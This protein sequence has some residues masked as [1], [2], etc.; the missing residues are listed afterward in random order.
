MI[1]RTMTITVLAIVLLHG[2]VHAQSIVPDPALPIGPFVSFHSD[3][4]QSETPA[5]G[6]A[7]TPVAPDGHTHT[8]SHDGLLHFSHPLI[9]ESPSPDT[10][11]R[12]D[13]FFRKV[14]G[15]ASYEHTARF[16][17]E[18]AFFPWLSAEVDAPYTYIDSDVDG[19]RSNLDTV[20]VAVKYA[21][22]TFAQHGVLVGGGIELG[23]PTGDDDKGIGSD[24]EL[25]VAPYIDA[26]WKVGPFELVGFLEFGIPVN[27][28][29]D[30]KDEVDLELGYNV[31]LLY[32]VTP[33]IEAIIELNGGSVALGEENEA[34]LNLSPGVKVQPWPNLPLQ[35]GVGVSFPL[36]GD[37]AYDV[38][39]ILSVFLHF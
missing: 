12:F 16:E 22:F 14:E 10:K 9:T 31:S 38:Q 4:A 21:N 19:H 6:P 37:D 8:H 17:G 24:H 20:S 23:L 32:H 30:E 39:T 36:T 2:A 34:V 7:V 1:I 25:E 18:Y 15:G 26:G 5:D 28:P 29:A 27:Q 3:A 13:Y 33:R 11:V 35:I